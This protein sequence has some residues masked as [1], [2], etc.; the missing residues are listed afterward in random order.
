MNVAWLQGDECRAPTDRLP[1]FF[2]RS[3]YMEIIIGKRQFDEKIEQR[4]SVAEMRMLR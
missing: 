1:Y 3:I 2:L 4:I